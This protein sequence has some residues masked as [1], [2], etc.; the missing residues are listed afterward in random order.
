[1][2]GRQPAAIHGRGPDQMN[3]F[4]VPRQRSAFFLLFELFVRPVKAGYIITDLSKMRR[5]VAD[6]DFYA[7][8]P[9]RDKFVSDH[10]DPF[11]LFLHFSFRPF[12]MDSTPSGSS[13]F[14][15]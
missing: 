14:Q 12:K 2:D 9:G 3:S 4:V 6:D 11:R 5:K 13:C 7:S 1:M 15:P 8:V 10:C